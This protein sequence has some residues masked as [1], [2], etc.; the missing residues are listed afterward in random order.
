M[1]ARV[2]VLPRG[3][4]SCAELCS[5]LARDPRA[6]LAI[7]ATAHAARRWVGH[8]GCLR[9]IEPPRPYCWACWD[10]IAGVRGAL[11]L[12]E[13][14]D[15][16]MSAA[17]T[18]ADYNEALAGVRKKRAVQARRRVVRAVH[19]RLGP[20]R[21]VAE[22]ARLLAITPHAVSAALEEGV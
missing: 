17:G 4:H 11:A 18:L 7:G 1:S 12:R 14:D 21:S 3:C 22:V 8:A 5:P 16:A 15:E 6:P 20:G 19:E 9:T 10:R 2:K 13:L